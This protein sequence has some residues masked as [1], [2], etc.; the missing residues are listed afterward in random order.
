MKVQ[1]ITFAGCP[2]ASAARE[3]LRRVLAAAGIVDR[4]E[5]VDTSD[6]D[7]PESLRSWGSPTVLIDGLDVGGQSTPSGP[8]CRLYSDDR[9]DVQGV[10]PEP[11]LLARVRG[12]MVTEDLIG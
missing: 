10:P 3:A 5:E 11:L 4:I 8:G 1:L 9:G 2:N 12:A 6:P 7:T